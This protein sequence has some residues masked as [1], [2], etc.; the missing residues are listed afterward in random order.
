[1]RRRDH[2]IVVAQ[3]LRDL[4]L[5]LSDG[6]CSFFLP[7]FP[8]PQ[9]SLSTYYPTI[10]CRAGSKCLALHRTSCSNAPFLSHFSTTL[11]VVLLSLFSSHLTHK[12]HQ[13]SSYIR[14]A[15]NG[16]EEEKKVLFLLMPLTLG[17]VLWAS[18]SGE[19]KNTRKKREKSCVCYSL[20]PRLLLLP[21]IYIECVIR[22]S[23]T[24]SRWSNKSLHR[25]RVIGKKQVNI[26]NANW[27]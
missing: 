24:R 10:H 25:P 13:F 11:Y 2:E 3:L 7:L 21:L 8:L 14:R 17:L 23:M 18:S 27:S 26:S 15:K 12:T 5:M 4:F 19:E 6:E 20:L 22:Y 1:M 16:T 9:T